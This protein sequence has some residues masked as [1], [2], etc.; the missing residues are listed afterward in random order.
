MALRREV[1]KIVNR[2]HKAAGAE[3]QA[4]WQ[5]RPIA[6]QSVL[7]ESFAGNGALCNPEAIFRSLLALSEFA[8]LEHVWALDE[9]SMTSD[10]I[11][12]E[13]A[14]NDRVRFVTR[15]SREYYRSISTCRWLVNNATF[16]LRFS[17][18]QGQTYLNT[19][20]GTPL[21][22]MGYDMPNGARESRNVL[23]NFLMADYLVAANP[24]MT[25]MY[26]RAYRLDGIYQGR[27]IETGYPRIDYQFGND[28]DHA[29]T[30]T[31]LRSRGLSIGDGSV[32]LYAPTWRGTSFSAAKAQVGM[33]KRLLDA[34][35]QRDDLRDTSV[36]LKVHQ[37]V[38]DQA[39]AD[40]SLSA[41]LVPNDVPTNKTLALA[42]VLVT[43]FSSV[44]FDFLASRRPVVF[45]A[46]D[47]ADYSES[48]G[49]YLEVDDWPGPSTNQPDQAAALIAGAIVG[50]S[51]DSD[52]G[53]SQA[54]PS[55][56]TARF[57]PHEDG[58]ATERVIDVVFRGND[59]GANVTSDFSTDKTSLLIYP[60]SLKPNGITN[61]A[62]NLLEHIDHDAYDV[63]VL[64]LD[65]G[66]R[67]RRANERRIDPRVRILYR[68]GG[69]GGSKLALPSRNAVVARGDEANV[70]LRNQVTAALSNE[71]RRCVGSARFDHIVDF[72][73]Y[74]GLMD[75]I[76]LQGEAR[77]HSIWQHNDLAADSRREVNGTRTQDKV[78][79]SVFGAYA[80]F[81]HIV[82]VS[83][84]L[85][86]VNRDNLGEY[87]DP[88]KFTFAPNTINADRIMQAAQGGHAVPAQPE[89]RTGVPTNLAESIEQ[90]IHEYEPEAVTA[91]LRTAL[92]L[93]K[94]MPFEN[95]VT[96]FI[97][98]GR[99]SPEKNQL[100]LIDAFAQ[101]HLERPDTR[102]VILGS[103]PLRNQLVGRIAELGID[104][105]VILTGQQSNPYAFLDRADC[106]VLSSDYEGQPMVILEA[107]IVGLPVVST[108]FDSVSGALSAHDGLIV[109]RSIDGL[110]DGLRAYLAGEVPTSVFDPDAYNEA[111]MQQFYRAIGA[112]RTAVTST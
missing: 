34:A 107:K 92:A 112:E 95:G 22:A 102:L 73:G 88:D 50:S 58:Q 87:A 16:P 3:H 82:S 1:K 75:H 111:A 7:Y 100:R 85:S 46:P 4:F 29:E 68:L 49:L 25:D 101:V 76:L 37:S 70:P 78:L 10:P 53:R 28:A 89:L 52:S 79:R 41:Y 60:G 14:G 23:R 103:G 69:M 40:P 65:T 77:S 109:P 67:G 84:A 59:N 90:L 19:W 24:H 57:C 8:D 72:G 51:P 9:A 91:E 6:Q 86:K 96:T 99:L 2:M 42:D 31:L 64:L 26:R 35:A 56:A 108:A 62:V 97:T 39:A 30:R 66:D 44:F 45:Y 55:M 54:D 71:W 21:K 94:W 17:K 48:R 12:T 98:A 93:E 15:E 36:I 32:V 33:L 38:Y 63:T 80:G 20:H 74:F 13:F 47:L 83:E 61:S 11:V 105:S 106:F 18:R 43:D 27:I 81:D 110:A 5:R 104:R